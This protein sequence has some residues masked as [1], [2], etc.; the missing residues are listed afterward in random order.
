VTVSALAFN[1]PADAS[2]F[3]ALA[4]RLAI[5]DDEA[6][7]LYADPT[8]TE[9][10]AERSRSASV[11]A[12]TT[13]YVDYSGAAILS[14]TRRGY[15]WAWRNTAGNIGGDPATMAPQGGGP[16]RGTVLTFPLAGATDDGTE[17]TPGFVGT[18]DRT[19]FTGVVQ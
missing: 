9:L 4:V 12:T 10:V 14:V 15:E 6:V 11:T 1:M 3:D 7:P 13:L 8:L 18:W 19:T 2:D 16:V 5:G 17:P